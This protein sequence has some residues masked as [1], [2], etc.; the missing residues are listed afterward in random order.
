MR[1]SQ[2]A[3]IL[4]LFPD[5]LRSLYQEEGQLFDCIEREGDMKDT[6]RNAQNVKKSFI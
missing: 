2:L 3:K 6:Q 4:T 5:W 1:V